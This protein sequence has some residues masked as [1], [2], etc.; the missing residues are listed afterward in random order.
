[1]QEMVIDWIGHNA[2]NRPDELATVDALS[3]SIEHLVEIAGQGGAS[4]F[5]LRN[6]MEV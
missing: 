3:V 4:E 2:A 6:T 5:E 1:M